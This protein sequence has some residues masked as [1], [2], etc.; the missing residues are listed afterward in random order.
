M[1]SKKKLS[2]III[3][4]E[5]I[6]AEVLRDY[7][8]QIAFLEFKGTCPDAIYAMELMKDE[9]IDVIFLDIHLPK[10]KGI[11]FLKSLKRKPQTILTTAYHE[12]AVDAFSE[13]VV[14]YLMKPIDFPRFVKAVN[15][16]R[17]PEIPHVEEPKDLTINGKTK[18]YHLFNVNKKLIKVYIEDIILIESLKDYS[19]VIT[20]QHS[21]VT[22]M[23]IGEV[24][25]LLEN[26]NFLRIHRSFVINPKY[27]TAFSAAEIELGKQN[28]PVGRSYKDAVSHFLESYFKI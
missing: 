13:D 15:K 18:E 19:K 24:E 10:L 12:Y 6:A 5:P 20:A 22:R 2:C 7:I 23:Q 1:G 21:L 17:F 9:A 25:S 14:D 26:K 11:E 3:E 27:I 28:L 4:D 8:D 16:L